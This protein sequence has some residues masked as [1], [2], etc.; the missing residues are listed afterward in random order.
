MWKAFAHKLLNFS[1]LL[2]VLALFGVLPAAMSWSERYSSASESP[3]LAPLVPGGKL[4]L[5]IIMGS[6]LVVMLSELFGN[7][8]HA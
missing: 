4:T 6:A 8:L 5:S 3:K 7:I 1:C 2:A